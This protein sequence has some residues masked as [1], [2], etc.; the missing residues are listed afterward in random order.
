M[1][2][3]KGSEVAEVTESDQRERQRMR[4][5]GFVALLSLR[6]SREE[7]HDPAPKI[8]RQAENGADL[9]HD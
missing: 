6:V 8:N 5:R 2:L 9:D 7:T 4:D 3:I 1:S